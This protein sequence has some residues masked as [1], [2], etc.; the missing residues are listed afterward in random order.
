LPSSVASTPA[1]NLGVA[2]QQHGPLFSFVRAILE[3]LF[4]DGLLGASDCRPRPPWALFGGYANPR[5]Y[6]G[7][8]FPFPVDCQGQRERESGKRRC[9]AV[10][11]V[12]CWGR[13]LRSAAQL[14]GEGHRG[15]P[16]RGRV[17]RD[18]CADLASHR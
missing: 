1:E 11:R 17:C 12:R 2:A 9:G 6:G 18:I 15:P 5:K 8:D 3:Q 4:F 10:G 14:A 16:G 13:P 7:K